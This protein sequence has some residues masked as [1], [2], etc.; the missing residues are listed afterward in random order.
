VRHALASD[1]GVI[2]NVRD[3]HNALVVPVRDIS[4]LGEAIARLLTFPDLASAIGARA[5]EQAKQ[6]LDHRVMLR[7]LHDWC[8][9]ICSTP[10]S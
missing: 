5:A 10:R 7:Q 4:G 9:D 2:E 1:G 8:L 3:G 6:S